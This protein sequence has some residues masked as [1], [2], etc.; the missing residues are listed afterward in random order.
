VATSRPGPSGGAA[1]AKGDKTMNPRRFHVLV[2]AAMLALAGLAFGAPYLLAEAP[3]ATTATAAQVT[4]PEAAGPVGADVTTSGAEPAQ[5]A[6]E[7]DAGDQDAAEVGSGQDTDNVQEGDQTAAEA[8]AE[9]EDA[10]GQ[11]TDNV[12]EGDQNGAGD[13][14]E[15]E[16][17][18]GQDT[19]DVQ[20]GDRNGA[21]EVAGQSASDVSDVNLGSTETQTGPATGAELGNASG[22]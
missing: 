12:Q 16:D 9:V 6:D 15:V 1:I 20:E 22:S 2:L 10:A 13:G 5:E 4:A 19:D 21:D 11:D 7:P 17:A 3:G 8:G 14:T 18:A